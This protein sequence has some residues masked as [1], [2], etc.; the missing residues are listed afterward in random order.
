MRGLVIA[1]AFAIAMSASSEGARAS[2]SL[3]AADAALREADRAGRALDEKFADLERID[4]ARIAPLLTNPSALSSEDL[5]AAFSAT[6]KLAFYATHAPYSR[7]AHYVDR[8][9]RIM[10][11]LV[12]RNAA[13]PEQI[14]TAFQAMVSAR[15]FGKASAL[16]TRFPDALA[17]HPVPAVA[18]AE[19]FDPDAPAVLALQQDGTLLA[20]NVDRSGAHVVVIVGCRASQHAVDEIARTPELADA[21]DNATTFWL[22]PAERMTD[23]EFLREWN[24]RFPGQQ[25]GFAYRNDAWKGVGFERMPSFQGFDGTHR[26]GLVLGWEP[27]GDTQLRAFLQPAD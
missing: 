6:D 15:Q 7:L 8:L 16:S 10:E 20:R 14:V 5:H 27:G 23:P 11:A 4:A 24:T 26:T 13:T 25:A 21:F 12:A 2:S 19:A 17:E 18:F 9:H 1:C 22:V 3:G